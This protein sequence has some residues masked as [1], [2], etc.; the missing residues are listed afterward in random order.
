VGRLPSR[1]SCMWMTFVNRRHSLTLVVSVIE[2]LVLKNSV[3]R[4][5]F[6]QG[7]FF[8]FVFFLRSLFLTRLP[9]LVA[10]SC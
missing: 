2:I 5:V 9:S 4:R 7:N 10:L 8:R 3:R 1:T 6:P